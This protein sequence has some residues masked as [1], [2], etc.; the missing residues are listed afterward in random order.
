MNAIE[1]LRFR[2][3]HARARELALEAVRRAPE[4]VV[5]EVKP[6]ARTLDQNAALHGYCSQIAKARPVWAGVPMQAEDWK[7]LLIEGHAKATGK[8]GTR[9]VPSL[10]DGGP[11]QLR[12]SSAKMSKERSSSLLSYIVAWAAE[13]GIELKDGH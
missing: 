7:N 6:A 3:V 5:V 11:V 2:L 4:G 13:H 1:R 10:E 8:V 12:E 9:L